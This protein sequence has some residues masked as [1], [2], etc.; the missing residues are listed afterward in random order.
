[1][2]DCM[3]ATR[4]I[5]NRSLGG[6]LERRRAE[7]DLGRVPGEHA[8]EAG[9]GTHQRIGGACVEIGLQAGIG[10]QNPTVSAPSATIRAPLT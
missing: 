5:G 7:A 9:I 1:M 4:A 2:C 6:Q 3:A 8:H 10:H